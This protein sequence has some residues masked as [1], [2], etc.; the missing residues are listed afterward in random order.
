MPPY[1]LPIVLLRNR[2]KTL[3]N[4]LESRGPGAH[5]KGLDSGVRRN[6]GYRSCNGNVASGVATW[7]AIRN[8]TCEIEYSV[9]HGSRVF[10][11]R[12]MIPQR[13]DPFRI[14]EERVALNIHEAP[15]NL[16][17]STK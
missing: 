13:C 7:A 15:E 9:S 4:T 17:L 16:P 10:I 2:P 11:F 3:C 8:R 5:N 14:Q 6:D 12:W 1:Y